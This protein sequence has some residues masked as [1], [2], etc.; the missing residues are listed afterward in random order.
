MDIREELLAEH[1]KSQT[2]KVVGYIGDDADRFAVLMRLFVGPDYRVS[3]R[4]AWSV[5]NCIER[6]PDLI[7]PYYSTLLEQ[8]ERDDAHIAVRRNV[9]RL[10]QFVDIP[11]RWQ[12][13]VF[14][15]CYKLAADVS[16]SIA[17]R[18]FSMTVAA[19]IAS[20]SPELFAEL[21]LVA[22]EHPEAMS[23]GLRSRWQRIFGI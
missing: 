14:D 12:G 13:R 22:A 18:C 16:Q 4:A 1:S 23:A 20:G 9:V 7:G 5:S 3:Q 19:N 2:A 6:Y 8:L 21:K 11:S 15:A 17:V 10:L